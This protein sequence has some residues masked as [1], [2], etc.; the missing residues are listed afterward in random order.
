MSRGPARI[1]L[2]TRAAGVGTEGT[3]SCKLGGITLYAPTAELLQREIAKGSSLLRN[4][5]SA[6]ASLTRQ[7]VQFLFNKLLT[8]RIDERVFRALLGRSLRL[9]E[10][11]AMMCASVNRRRF[12]VYVDAEMYDQFQSRTAAVRIW[13]QSSGRLSVAEVERKFLG[14]RQWGTWSSA[15][16]LLAHLAHL[17]EAEYGDGSS[18]EWPEVLKNARS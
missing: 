7:N 9:G 17:G 11:S 2:S 5:C 12:H 3:A 1:Q 6:H 15:S 16:H 13:L 14:P 18:F 4:V 10:I 8:C